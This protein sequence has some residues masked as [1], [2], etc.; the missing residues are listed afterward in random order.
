MSATSSVTVYS[1]SS[2]DYEPPDEALRPDKGN[3]K[4]FE[5][6]NNPF[7]FSPGQLNK[8]LNPKSLSAF[9]ALG[10]LRGLER[11]LRT[12]LTAGL[13][14]DETRIDGQV[15]FEDAVSAGSDKGDFSNV[16][17]SRQESAA[18]LSR[19]EVK[20]QFQD[21]MRVYRDNRL[22]ERKPDGILV[23]IW[24][25]YNDKILILLTVAAVVSLALG[26]YETLSGESGV[27]W[28][29]GVAICV[30]IIIVVTVG[31]ANDWQK[32]RQ[33]VKLNKRVSFTHFTDLQAL[34]KKTERR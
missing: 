4:D 14:V 7:A 32:E 30:A 2:L 16:S 15:S 11:G 24:R 21:R 6:T 26:I 34:T 12:S 27:D 3:E 33:F 10:G 1:K 23:L 22:P 5:V 31:A 29:E 25:A 9:K 17:L 13:S 19:H 18:S 28:V 20:G 8:L